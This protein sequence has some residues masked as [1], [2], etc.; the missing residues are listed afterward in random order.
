MVLSPN[1]VQHY[2]AAI[3]A[4]R[5][6]DPLPQQDDRASEFEPEDGP[7]QKTDA[8]HPVGDAEIDMEHAP[9]PKVVV[10][11]NVKNYQDLQNEADSADKK[12]GHTIV[13]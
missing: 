10:R 1:P 2:A 13:L 12:A 6:P 7:V 4:D 3:D 5:N 11:R 8:L 9:D